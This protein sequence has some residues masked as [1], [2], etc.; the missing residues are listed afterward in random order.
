VTEVVLYSAG[1]NRTPTRGDSKWTGLR[2][3]TEKTFSN[4][5]MIGDADWKLEEGAVVATKVMGFLSP[6]LHLAGVR[7]VRRER[8]FVPQTRPTHWSKRTANAV[9]RL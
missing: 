2:C 7:P 5:N 4:W 8:A 3:S 1:E 6:R 9:L